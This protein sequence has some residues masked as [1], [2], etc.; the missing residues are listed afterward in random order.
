MLTQSESKIKVSESEAENPRDAF[1]D[2]KF[3]DVKDIPTVKIL[4]DIK[5]KMIKDEESF[6]GIY[7]ANRTGDKGIVVSYV[8][9]EPQFL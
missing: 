1:K 4:P 8:K 9:K 6:P 5:P 7:I 2:L 3:Q